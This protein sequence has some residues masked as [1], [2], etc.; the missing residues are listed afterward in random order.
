MATAIVPPGPARVYSMPI[1]LRGEGMGL[2]FDKLREAEAGFISEQLSRSRYFAAALDPHAGDGRPSLESLDRAFENYLASG[3]EPSGTNDVV[4][5]VGIVFGVEL[6][7]RLGFQW[8]IATDDYGTDLAVLARP[9]RGDVTIFPADFVAKRFERREAP[10][11]V[12]AFAEISQQLREIA[13]EWGD[14]D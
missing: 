4:Q 12:A 3:G 5:I 11:L 7:E 14:S 6:V 9:G 10:F 2:S 13:A 1:G 8:V